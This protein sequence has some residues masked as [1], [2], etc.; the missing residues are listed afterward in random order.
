MKKVTP[1]ISSSII[2]NI[3]INTVF[4]MH[5]AYKQIHYKK[6]INTDLLK[7]IKGEQNN[8]VNKME[9]LKPNNALESQALI[10]VYNN[11]CKK[12]RCLECLSLNCAN[13]K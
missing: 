11:F 10:E 1:P 9:P 8:I 4:Q 13:K 7:K 6:E 3:T 5:E 12:K 2:E